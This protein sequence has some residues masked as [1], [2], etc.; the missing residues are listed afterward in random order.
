MD[1]WR[2]EW[3]LHRQTIVPLILIG[4]GVVGIWRV[5]IWPHTSDGK[6]SRA[7]AGIEAKVRELDLPA[8]ARLDNVTSFFMDEA[9]VLTAIGLYSTS[10]HCSGV[11]EHYR[12]EFPKHG[13]IY[14]GE[15]PATEKESRNLSF[16]APGHSASLSC[17]DN[18]KLLHYQ[19]II[20]KW[21]A[22]PR[23]PLQSNAGPEANR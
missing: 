5:W 3:Q 15:T 6:I 17:D 2:R 7:K 4:M 8:G 12:K 10:S 9:G 18:G 20:V 22:A 11:E 19:I 16:S 13:F 23:K 1:T 14:E 21:D